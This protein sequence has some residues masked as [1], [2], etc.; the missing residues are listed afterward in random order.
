MSGP[1]FAAHTQPVQLIFGGKVRHL[2][3]MAPRKQRTRATAQ[4]VRH[5]CAKQ[6]RPSLLPFN[7][8]S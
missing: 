2:I 6:H 5:G 4:F 7:Q 3:I 1:L 8:G